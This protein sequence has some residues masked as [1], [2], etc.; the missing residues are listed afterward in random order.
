M[1]FWKTV[2][3]TCKNNLFNSF[4]GAKFPDK[5]PVLTLRSIYHCNKGKPMYKILPGCPYK[6]FEGYIEQQVELFKTECMGLPP[7]KESHQF[8]TLEN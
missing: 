1:N 6:N 4:T 7:T 5:P 2:H 8:V 3:P